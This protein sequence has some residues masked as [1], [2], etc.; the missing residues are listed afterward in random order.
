MTLDYEIPKFVVPEDRSK[1]TDEPDADGR[2]LPLLGP[3]L[4]WIGSKNQGGGHVPDDF[5]WR[6]NPK[7][8][9]EEV[10]MG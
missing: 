10:S 2:H 9:Q 1:V 8:H 7:E 5:Q 3:D 4:D 6:S